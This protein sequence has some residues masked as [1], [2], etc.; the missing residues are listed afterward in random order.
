VGD[1]AEYVL[2]TL[3]AESPL[4]RRPLLRKSHQLERV[5]RAYAIRLATEDFWQP[6]HN[7]HI[8]P[9]G[10]TANERVRDG[11][12]S[13]P[14][15]YASYGNNVESL[16]AGIGAEVDVLGALLSSAGHRAHLM[17]EGDF[18]K[19]QDWYGVGVAQNEASTYRIYWVILIAQAGEWTSGE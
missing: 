19:L 14:T 12:F 18:Y 8:S 16:A 17:G 1:F 7:A 5:A 6:G 9:D 15:H 2:S 4:Q 13:L 3:I 11:G 10:E